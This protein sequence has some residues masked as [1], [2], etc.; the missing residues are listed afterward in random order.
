MTRYAM[1]NGVDNSGVVNSGVD[2]NQVN[3]CS[4]DSN[5][6]NSR[7]VDSNQVNS[8][9]VAAK[10]IP[11][12]TMPVSKWAGGET[13]QLAIFPVNA[14]VAA[15]DF[16]WRFSSATVLQDGAFTQFP[17]HQRLLA[18]RQGAGFTLQVDAHQQQ[19]HSQQQVL[20]FAG[21]AHSHASL[22]AGA[23]VDINLMVDASLQA[24]LW[25]ANCTTEFQ[26]WPSPLLTGATLL[27][28]ADQ[29][30]LEI[31][32]E[33]GTPLLQLAVGEVLQLQSPQQ[34]CLVRAANAPCTAV[35]AWLA[36]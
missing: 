36:P 9:G 11:A 30:P 32:L 27:I 33:P 23:I 24:N 14:T 31:C 34:P 28:Y 3:S 16:Q 25:S 29:A 15:Q 7:G 13:R 12:A 20:R 10:I 6:V 21:C 1:P 22:I 8:R 5:Q 2:S 18:L 17:K 19:V 4:V 35:F 26:P